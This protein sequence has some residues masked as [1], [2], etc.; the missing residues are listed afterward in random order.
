MPWPATAVS[1]RLLESSI[2]HRLPA[3][4]LNFHWGL[5]VRPMSSACD[6]QEYVAGNIGKM[7][8]LHSIISW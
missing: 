6:A 7:P 8:L 3:S 2:S 5:D 1:I 4:W